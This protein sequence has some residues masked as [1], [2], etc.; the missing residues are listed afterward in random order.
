MAVVEQDNF[1]NISWHSEQAPGLTSS[2]SPSEEV[3]TPEFGRH[4][5]AG[6]EDLVPGRSGEILECTVSEPHKE[7]DGTKDAY[8]S[9]LINTNVSYR[10]Q[11]LCVAQC[12][13]N[14]PASTNR[15]VIGTID[16]VLQLPAI[17]H[18]RATAIYRFCLSLQMPHKRI[19]GRSCA[20]AA[21]QAA[22]GVCS[23]RSVWV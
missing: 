2:Q 17:R 19:S 5:P 15:R 12:Q 4:S 11:G 13:S 14:H 1:S 6:D 9:Y 8:V 22:D 7:N 3:S 20:A 10:W 21:G 18:I 16:N 23:R